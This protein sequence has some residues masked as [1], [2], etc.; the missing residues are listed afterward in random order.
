MKSRKSGRRELLKQGAAVAGLTVGAIH[1]AQGQTSVTPV[2]PNELYD[3][4]VRSRFVT[5]ARI[6]TND[7]HGRD[8]RPGVP[9]DWGFRTP[10][11]DSVGIITPASLHFI[12]NHAV[13]PPDVDPRQHRLLIHG[14]VERPLIFTLEELQRLPSVSRIHFVECGG[15]STASGAWFTPG[16][17]RTLPEAT[18]QQ[19]HGLTSCSEWT[20]VPLS[21]LLGEAG[22]KSEG[23]WIVAEGTERGMHTKSIPIEKA[24]DDVL[25]VY[26]QNG[27]SIR[28]EQGYP[29]RL[30]VPGW[31]GINNV[32][33]LRRIK[34]M[35]QPSMGMRELTRY[36]RLLPS[37]KA[38]WFDFEMGAKSVITRPSGGQRL[39]GRGFYEI[40]GLAWSG[41]G[42]IRRVEVSTDN[43]RSWTEA[44]LQQPVHRKAHSRFR[45]AW[46]WDG[47]ETVLLSRCSDDQGWE[48]PSVAELA[49][50]LG[51]N[52]L[53]LDFFKE[54]PS[55][56]SH[57][58][59]IQSWR[60]NRDGSVE[61]ALFA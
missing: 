12:V 10:L 56:I 40:T 30:L 34:V 41:G 37:G 16:L 32:K 33:W 15:N 55:N 60:V 1:S 45:L 6:G 19:T 18:V 53:S 28:P 5:S 8:I 54:R 46:N 7:I 20:G 48:Q 9:R 57:F 21:L 11:Q 13:D 50:I 25:V 42:T 27:E 3:Y 35:H 24:L 22:V 14:L 43:G 36:T 39:Q 61:N 4:G 26:G 59:A 29:L 31:E 44:E 47:G 49:K 17:V 51:L 2:R 52:N 58:N 38:H 23:S